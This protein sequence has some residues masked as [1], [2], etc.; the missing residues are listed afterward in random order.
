M[1][2]VLKGPKLQLT[3]RFWDPEVFKEEEREEPLLLLVQLRL[4]QS[5]QKLDGAVWEATCD[6]HTSL[7]H[8]L[9]RFLKQ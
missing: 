8:R 7:F 9:S 3:V 4:N 5:R 2:T 6:N 1:N